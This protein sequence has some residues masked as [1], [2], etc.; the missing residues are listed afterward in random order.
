MKI[1]RYIIAATLFAAAGTMAV[2]SYALWQ[3]STVANDCDVDS[4]PGRDLTCVCYEDE[5]CYAVCGE[6]R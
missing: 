6:T 2:I 1:E 3:S 4:C 5:P